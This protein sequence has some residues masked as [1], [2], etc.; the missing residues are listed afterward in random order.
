MAES[1]Y[2]MKKSSLVLIY[3]LVLLIIF[4]LP[5]QVSARPFDW[6]YSRFATPFA[7]F[8]NPALIGSNPG[9]TIGLDMRY[10]D[11]VDYDAR[12]ALTI[13]LSR[14][15]KR[16]EYLREGARKNRKYNYAN[17]S[18]MSSETTISLGGI[19]AGDEDYDIN[20]GF[21]TPIRMIQTGLSLC[22]AHRNDNVTG[23][24][25]IN[26]TMNIGFSANVMR[27]GIVYFMVNNIN[28]YNFN[29][30]LTRG[31]DVTNDL[32]FSLGTSGS[33]FSDTTKI[34]L[35]YDI[36]F[37][38]TPTGDI[39]TIGR[40][41]GMLR[42][43]LDLTYVYTSRDITGQMAVASLGYG[44]LRNEYGKISHNVFASLGLEFVNKASSSALA[45]GYGARSGHSEEANGAFMYSLV[46]KAGVVTDEYLVS[47]I[48]C[49]SVDSARVIIGMSSGGAPV[50]SWVLK[51]E[52]H[53]GD[54]IKTFSG[55]NVIPASIIWD[56]LSSEGDKPEDDVIY[57][58]LVIR[59]EKRVVESEMISMEIVKGR[60]K[61][62]R[63]L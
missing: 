25:I 56:G 19:Y 22:L 33:P 47:R 7:V 2:V 16:E 58:K 61:P 12:L 39:F 26:G 6:Y 50:H 37:T 51:I 60:P 18:Y 63:D 27:S 48:Y 57:A 49:V 23:N 31:S 59:G 8:Y 1:V 11:T 34:F 9:S 45:G 5:R 35:P 3:A 30:M 46:N 42:L 32:G 41:A 17:P 10:A 15:L 36:L 14:V 24:D 44:F 13:P 62:K 20:V 55:G 4:L 53:G 54:N 38:Y 40:L 43:N 29:S 21:A 52:T 28:I